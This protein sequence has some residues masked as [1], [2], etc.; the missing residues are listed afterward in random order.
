MTAGIEKKV[1]GIAVQPT[2][3]SSTD[4]IDQPV[5]SEVFQATASRM[6]CYLVRRIT[7]SAIEHRQRGRRQL[8]LGLIY[9][10]I[11]HGAPAP[12]PFS[13]ELRCS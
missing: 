7:S 2:R 13:T 5:G 6:R 4:I 12:V 1:F 3:Q 11:G 8:E 10:D 9:T